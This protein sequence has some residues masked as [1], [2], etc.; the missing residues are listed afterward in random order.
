MKFEDFAA[1]RKTVD[2]VVR[3]F[4]VIGEAAGRIPEDICRAH[5]DIPWAEMRTMRNLV[6]HDYFGVDDKIRSC[7]I[8]VRR[9]C[10]RSFRCS[11]LYMEIKSQ[12]TGE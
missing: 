5:A 9:I 10:R 1:G 7:G 3:N 12:D 11:E 2:A 6:V 4:I 8:P